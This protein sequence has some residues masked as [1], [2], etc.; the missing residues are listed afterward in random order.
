MSTREMAKSAFIGFF[1]LAACCGLH[2]CV[3]H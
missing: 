2:I 3:G 1:I